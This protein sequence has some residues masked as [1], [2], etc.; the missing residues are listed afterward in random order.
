MQP[1]ENK[2]IWCESNTLFRLSVRHD[3]CPRK[4]CLGSFPQYNNS[5]CTGECVL[6]I[7]DIWVFLHYWLFHWLM[8]CTIIVFLLLL[9]SLFLRFIFIYLNFA[10][11]E[12]QKQ[13]TLSLLFMFMFFMLVFL[14]KLKFIL[15]FRMVN[16]G[17]KHRIRIFKAFFLMF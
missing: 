5:D 10:R 7:L 1:E 2:I 12:W 6:F 14:Q 9:S 8:G 17:C 3:V 16:M 15:F 11:H 13:R 4:W